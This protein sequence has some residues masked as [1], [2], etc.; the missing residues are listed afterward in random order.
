MIH[1][2]NEEIPGLVASGAADVMITEILE[3]AWYTAQDSRLAAPLIQEPFTRGELGVLMPE[4]S[5][6]L[7]AFVNA[8]LA[9]ERAS[10]R[11]EELARTYVYGA[12]E[13]EA[14]AAA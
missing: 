6:T 1:A 13:G 2:V 12:G 8:F 7:L 11:L 10:G 9:E 14:D 3:A 4:G 5:E